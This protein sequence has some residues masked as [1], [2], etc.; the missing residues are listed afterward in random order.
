MVT[1]QMEPAMT[2][3]IP[4]PDS[5]QPQPFATYHQIPGQLAWWLA[6]VRIADTA[7]VG[8]L[9]FTPLVHA[10]PFGPAPA[11]ARRDH[12]AA[13]CRWASTPAAWSSTVVARNHGKLPVLILEGESIVGAE[14]ESCG[15]ADVMIAPVPKRACP[16]DAPSAAVGITCRSRPVSAADVPVEP[17]M[18]ARRA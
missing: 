5:R 17:M 7:T 10:G 9:E 15:H 6:E 18:R 14:T 12:E 2:R 13:R 11:A 3:M 16:W 8:A 4:G 1:K